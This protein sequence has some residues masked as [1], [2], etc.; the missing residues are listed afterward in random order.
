[1]HDCAT[2]QTVIVN[3]PDRLDL[4][5]LDKTIPTCNGFC[6]GQLVL[7]ASGGV[8][9]YTYD[10]NGQ[11]GVQQTG[12]CS[13]IYPVI[14]MDANDCIITRSVELDQPESISITVVSETLAT[15]TDGCDGALE[16]IASG[17]NGGYQYTWAGGGNTTVKSSLCPGV[18]SVSIS[19][20]KGCT[21]EEK[22]SLSNTPS[23]PLDLG[24]GVTLCVGQTYTLNAG[25]GWTSSIWSGSNGFTAIGERVVLNDPGQYLLEVTNSDG[26]VARDTFLL[27]TSL[28]LLKANFILTSTAFTMDT[29]VM[30]DVSWPLPDAIVWTFPAEMK[31]IVE[32][33]DVVYGQFENAGSYQVS[34]IARLAECVDEL[35]KT[36][37]I[38]D[39]EEDLDGG[40]LGHEEFVKEFSLYPNPNDGKFDVSIDLLA[41]SSVILSVWNTM[42]S[43]MVGKISDDGSKSYLKHIDFRPLSSGTYVLRLDHAKGREY[44]R[45]IVH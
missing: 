3:A 25:S 43:T 45:F 11:S 40:R 32:G 14:L 30:I 19:D 9:G 20:M 13:G 31:K 28:D 42:T 21:N 33:G 6:D 24:G 1:V 37:T 4:R 5:V 39:G 8:G 10:W 2:V 41:E 35:T 38:L 15:C 27:E 18:Y 16:V 34:L 7:E 44:I 12:L 36:I 17:G 26:C 22:V 29:V 23:L